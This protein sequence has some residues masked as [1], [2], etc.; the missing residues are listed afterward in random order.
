MSVY[1][2][3]ACHGELVF[4]GMF[5]TSQG[6]DPGCTLGPG[7]SLAYSGTAL[8]AQFQALR[9]AQR[10]NEKI[11]V[12]IGGGGGQYLGVGFHPPTP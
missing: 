7:Q 10:T 3:P 4:D 12:Y 11:F 1:A 2:D 5:C 8:A 9:E 6:G